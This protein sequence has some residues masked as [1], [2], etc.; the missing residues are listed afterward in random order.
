MVGYKT[1]QRFLENERKPLR[2]NIQKAWHFDIKVSEQDERLP[3]N[4]KQGS[5]VQQKRVKC[6]NRVCGFAKIF[7][8]TNLIGC[9][10]R[11]MMLLEAQNTTLWAL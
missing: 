1:A 9:A 3:L 6:A 11:T 5:S 2:S 10:V 8:S 7:T 4:R